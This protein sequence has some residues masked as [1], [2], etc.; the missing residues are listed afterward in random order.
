MERLNYFVAL[1]P[2]TRIDHTPSTVFHYS[3]KLLPVI[4]PLVSLLGIDSVL[5]PFC[6]DATDLICSHLPELCKLVEG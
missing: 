2:V 1:A 3:V 6:N 4:E 5:G